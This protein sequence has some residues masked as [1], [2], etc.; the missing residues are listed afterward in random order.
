MS[1]L[2]TYTPGERG[3]LLAAFTPRAFPEPRGYTA[4][5]IPI[6]GYVAND[7]TTPQDWHHVT[8]AAYEVPALVLVI[9]S[10]GINWLHILSEDIAPAH[11]PAEVIASATL[12]GRLH[13]ARKAAGVIYNRWTDEGSDFI[14][15]VGHMLEVELHVVEI[16]GLRVLCSDE[17]G[18]GVVFY[19]RAGDEPP[20]AVMNMA[21][22]VSQHSE[23]AG[24]RFTTIKPQEIKA[25]PTKPNE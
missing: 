25:S 13:E 2:Y 23:E 15:R 10:A 21:G 20:P 19:L 18:N 12:A 9:R 16:H 11:T 17:R 8:A 3:K 24:Y 5:G 14:G 1:H 6:Y 7:G 22:I 4:D